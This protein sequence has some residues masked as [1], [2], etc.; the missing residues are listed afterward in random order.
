MSRKEGGTHLQH[1]GS[2][3]HHVASLPSPP[4]HLH[5]IPRPRAPR[6][7]PRAPSRRPLVELQ[8]RLCTGR[9]GRRSRRPEQGTYR[10]GQAGG[11]QDAGT[12]R[13]WRG[14]CAVESPEVEGAPGG[15]LVVVYGALMW[16]LGVS[17]GLEKKRE[18]EKGQGSGVGAGG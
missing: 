15:G 2:P 7:R 8:S 18:R 16:G 10:A 17:F 5:R 1:P 12:C 14:R 3:P 11:G 13:R 4:S 9:Q 6:G